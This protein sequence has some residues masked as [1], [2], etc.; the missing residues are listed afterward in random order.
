MEFTLIEQ[1]AV[2]LIVLSTARDAVEQINSV[3]RR[4]GHPVHCTWIPSLRDLGDALGQLNPELLLFVDTGAADLA[5]AA[6]VRDQ[7]APS[8]PLV[9]VESDGL[10]GQPIMDLFEESKHA[11][12]KGALA[13]CLHGRW[14]D[15]TLQL[16]A[17]LPD[18]TV[19]LLVLVFLF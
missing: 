1:N 15:H 7:L 18:G 2:P 4:A 11:A 12:L 9:V 13:A 6:S 16:N 3:L 17:V 10:V 8:V 19:F 5:G 14:S